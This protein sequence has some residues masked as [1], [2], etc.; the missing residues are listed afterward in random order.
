MNPAENGM[1]KRHISMIGIDICFSCV[2]ELD[3]KFL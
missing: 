1:G 2:V 3:K